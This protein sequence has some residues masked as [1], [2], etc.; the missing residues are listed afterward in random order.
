MTTIEGSG[1]YHDGVHTYRARVYYDDTDA[2]GVVYYANYLRLAERAR[3]ELMRHF[4][5]VHTDLR[6]REDVMFAVRRCEIDYLRPAMLDDL[7][8]VHT[9]ITQIGGA[10][11]CMAQSICRDGGEI[12]RLQV[13]L[14][15]VTSGGRATRFPD[16]VRKTLLPLAGVSAP[17]GNTI[18]EQRD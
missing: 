18:Q 8:E 9:R 11:M 17:E 2:G 13:Q 7:L 15:C 14:A 12:A 5:H 16:Y 3:T 4:G 6:E 1:E 10:S